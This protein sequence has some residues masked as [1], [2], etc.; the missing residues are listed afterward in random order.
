MSLMEHIPVARTFLEYFHKCHYIIEATRFASPRHYSANIFIY[1]T[2]LPQR[3]I[4]GLCR[5]PT[6]GFLD[7]FEF[8]LIPRYAE[9]DAR[10]PPKA[11]ER[12]GGKDAL[13]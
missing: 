4:S 7:Y 11:K 3:A 6:S 5:P 12:R 8:P 2:P 10:L 1:F 9:I 13:P